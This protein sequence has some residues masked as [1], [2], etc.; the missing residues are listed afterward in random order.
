M[1]IS[2]LQAMREADFDF[3]NDEDDS[4]DDGVTRHYFEDEAYSYEDGGE[5]DI[6]DLNIPVHY[7]MF[8]DEMYEYSRGGH[9]SKGEMVWNKLSQSKRMEFLYKHFTPEITPRSQEILVGKNWNF[10]PKNVK[11]KFEAIYANVEDY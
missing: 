5:V 11:I 6:D 3:D 2:K 7:T 9:V 8:E 4:Y 1:S 10:L